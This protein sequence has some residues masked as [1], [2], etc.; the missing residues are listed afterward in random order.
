MCEL[1]IRRSHEIAGV[2]VFYLAND[3][4]TQLQYSFQEPERVKIVRVDSNV[5]GG[6]KTL[7]ARTMEEADRRG[8][9][10]VTGKAQKDMNLRELRHWYKAIG[11]TIGHDLVLDG[12]V[13]RVY[14][15][16]LQALLRHNMSYKD[17]Y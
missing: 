17:C 3:P 7:I 5:R 1:L 15:L 12:E 9:K 8:A 14:T 16:C 4:S 13:S 2:G 10:R 11:I 6:G